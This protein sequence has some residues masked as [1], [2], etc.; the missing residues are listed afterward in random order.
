MMKKMLQYRF[1][2]WQQNLPPEH[3]TVVSRGRAVYRDPVT[4]VELLDFKISAELLH[5]NRQTR[6]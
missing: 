3:M 5:I 2:E 6:E 4:V 1:S